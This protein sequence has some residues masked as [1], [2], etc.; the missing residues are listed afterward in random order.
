ML[1]YSSSQTPFFLF[2]EA[3]YLEVT[4]CQYMWLNT[5]LSLLL[6]LGRSDDN[7]TGRGIIFNTMSVRL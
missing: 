3:L 1:L 6:S 4:F 7:H 2:L 5:F